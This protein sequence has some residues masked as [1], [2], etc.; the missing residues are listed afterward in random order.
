MTSVKNVSRWLSKGVLRTTAAVALVGSI[1]FGISKGVSHFAGK[2]ANE[3]TVQKQMAV[4]NG[5]AFWK[6]PSEK[7]LTR[8]IQDI[9][10]GKL[11]IKNLEKSNLIGGYVKITK[12]D[13]DKTDYITIKQGEN[14]LAIEPRVLTQIYSQDRF[15]EHSQY[16]PKLAET[17]N[18]FC[19]AGGGV[20]ILKKDGAKKFKVDCLGEKENL[21]IENKASVFFLSTLKS[22]DKKLIS[23]KAQER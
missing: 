4:K 18:N 22:I 13:I 6:S 23:I 17:F 10:T 5:F 21:T 15:N 7:K 12:V 14:I 19:K 3:I 1:G 9:A 8:V 11:K 16:A 20:M 2:K